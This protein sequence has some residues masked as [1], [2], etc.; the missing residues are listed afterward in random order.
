M[1]IAFFSDAYHPRISG[2]VTSIDEFCKILVER[3]HEVRIVCP[4]YPGGEDEGMSGSFPSIRVPS[5]SGLVSNED[6]LAIPWLA[7]EALRELEEFNPQAVHVQTEFTVGALGRRYCRRH[8]MPIL[9]TCHT[10]YE[11]YV[12]EY[13]PLMPPGLGRLGTRIWLRSVYARD[14]LIV[15][16][17]YN[18]RDVLVSYG[19]DRSYEVI[20][21]GVDEK[22]FSPRLDEAKALRDRLAKS[23]RGFNQGPLLAYVGRIRKEKNLT[24]LA[25][26]FALLSREA[27]DAHLLM[28]GEGPLKPELQRFFRTAGLER[29][30]VW[31]DYLARDQLPA[32]YSAADIFVFPSKTET[33]GLVTIESMLCGTPVVGVNRMG[34]AEILGSDSGGLL[35]EDDPADFADKA[36]ILIRDPLL[37]RT[38]AAQ[39]R[40]HALA[41]STAKSCDKIENLYIRLFG[42]LGL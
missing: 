3:G 36:L 41:W 16:P 18:I 34:T 29:K 24:L 31:M 39:A 2:Q 40:E 22:L 4:S 13:L 35:A 15:T 42:H 7:H 37:R 8:G 14:D 33:Q 20:P 1:R 11:M 5:G 6:R 38:K 17:S 28:V 23:H 30:V 25:E 26:A 12:K 10:H 21:T 19:L 9:S 27:P 32:V